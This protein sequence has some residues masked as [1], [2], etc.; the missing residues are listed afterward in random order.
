[1]NHG[2]IFGQNENNNDHHLLS[3]HHVLGGGVGPLTYSHL[4]FMTTLQDRHSHL[5]FLRTWYQLHILMEMPRRQL[6]TQAWSLRGKY[7]ISIVFEA[8][9][10]VQ[11]PVVFRNDEQIVLI[12]VTLCA[13]YSGDPHP[14]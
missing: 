12:T 13:K 9:G 8:L 14:S 3:I 10:Q 4:I 7:N 2:K 1:M 11:I 5:L 6:G